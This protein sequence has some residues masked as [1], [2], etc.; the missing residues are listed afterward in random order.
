MVD[1]QRQP[2][3]VNRRA[4]LVMPRLRDE[5]LSVVYHGENGLCTLKESAQLS[6]DQQGSDASNESAQ[7][8]VP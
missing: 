8:A 7:S 6:D 4:R 2:Q 5:S 1:S 3:T